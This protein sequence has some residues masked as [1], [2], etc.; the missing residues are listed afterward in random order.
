MKYPRVAWSLLPALVGGVVIAFGLGDSPV[1]LAN[2]LG[3]EPSTWW[4]DDADAPAFTI[5]YDERY[6]EAHTN[7]TDET[8]FKIQYDERYAEAHMDDTDET[9]FT[10]QYDERYA[11]AHMDNVRN[12]VSELQDVSR[13]D[14]SYQYEYSYPEAKYGNIEALSNKIEQAEPENNSDPDDF[15]RFGEADEAASGETGDE[16]SQWFGSHDDET[17]V[18]DVVRSW[19]AR[20][21]DELAMAIHEVSERID[22]SEQISAQ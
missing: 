20:S 8:A 18:L 15:K 12:N 2:D 13:E 11:E 3:S 7:D 4:T 21:L 17:S 10:I 9:D 14:Y 5:Q 22:V 19:T 1:G 16:K 6:A